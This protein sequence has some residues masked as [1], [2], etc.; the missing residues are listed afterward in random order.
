M[1]K[2]TIAAIA[3][4]AL[5]ASSVSTAE[6]S[7]SV[8]PQDVIAKVRE[9]AAYLAKKGRPGLA[10]FERGDSP[11]IWKD[12]YVFVYD[13]A[14]DV[15]V[16]HPVATSR[17][18]KISSLKGADGKAYGSSLCEAAKR[19]GGG[20][21]E[22]VWPKPV[23]GTNGQVVYSDQAFRKVS[24]MLAVEG[25]PYEV[26]AGIYNDAMSIDQLDALAGK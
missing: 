3:I 18:V 13:C 7:E 15:I 17:K 23:V 12:T 24:Y 22:Y 26:G 21:I 1:L 10:M 25:Q 5:G 11:F 9:A 2:H 20:W 6:E 19:P 8:T 4:T 16:A 14:A